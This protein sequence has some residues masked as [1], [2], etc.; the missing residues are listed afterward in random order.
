MVL[1][2]PQAAPSGDGRAV[3]IPRAITVKE[4][5]ELLS[6]SG[7]DV[8][9]ELMKNGVMATLN[10]SIDFDTA[11]IVASDLGFE[12]QEVQAAPPPI[13][14][15]AADRRVKETGEGLEP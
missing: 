3:E 4:L 1:K 12:P 2:S 11:A 6:V 14:A 5:G 9:K 15:P 8:I 10:Q 13:A 7:V